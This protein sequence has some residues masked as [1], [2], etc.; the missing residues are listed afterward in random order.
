MGS[1]AI[2]LAKRALVVLIRALALTYGVTVNCNR[3]SNDSEVLGNF[4]K[5][6]ELLG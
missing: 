5:V 1:S 6:I 3:D 2:L 4:R